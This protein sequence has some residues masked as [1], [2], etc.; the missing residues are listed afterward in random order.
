MLGGEGRNFLVSSESTLP[1]LY[2][3][4]VKMPGPFANERN[5]RKSVAIES[6]SNCGGD[7]K[8]FIV[9]LEEGRS[10][11]LRKEAEI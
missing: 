11:P 4:F 3:N 5:R 2:I 10:E 1:D 6:N 7:I 9:V 8:E